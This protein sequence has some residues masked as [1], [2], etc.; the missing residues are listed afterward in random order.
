MTALTCVTTMVAWWAFFLQ[1]AHRRQ[2]GEDVSDLEN[3][4]I[5]DG[6]PEVG[7][8][9]PSS[10]WPITLAGALALSMVGTAIGGT[11]LVF[12]AVPLVLICIVGWVMETYRGY[13]AR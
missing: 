5:D 11:W 6:D 3:A 2:G 7:D 9:H 10:W 8:F 13:Y 4:E 12:A 1:V